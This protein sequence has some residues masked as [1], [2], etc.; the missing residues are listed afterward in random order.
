MNGKVIDLVSKRPH[1]AGTARCC[2]PACQHEWEAVAPQG[3]WSLECPE[4]GCMRG[5]FRNRISPDEGV[6]IF[7]CTL[8]RT[9]LFVICMDYVICMGCGYKHIWDRVDNGA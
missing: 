7:T 6:P 5:A 8:C 2:N 9:Q 3:V 4:C 1:I